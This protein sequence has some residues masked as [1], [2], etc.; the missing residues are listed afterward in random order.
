MNYFYIFYY[1]LYKWIDKYTPRGNTWTSL[2]TNMLVSLFFMM[3]I[4]LIF[5]NTAKEFDI[6]LKLALVLDLIL[7][8]YITKKVD[9]DKI[10]KFDDLYRKTDK[11][12]IIMMK[13]IVFFYS[14]FSFYTFFDILFR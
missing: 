1:I 6:F 10:E 11:R 14:I 8:V 3:N 5:D 9:K 2:R 12:I 13:I 4:F 7:L